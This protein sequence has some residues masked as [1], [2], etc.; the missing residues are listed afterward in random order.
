M[1][2]FVSNK[3]A[4]FT[5]ICLLFRNALFKEW[6]FSQFISSN[7][8]LYFVYISFCEET[9]NQNG[10]S[11]TEITECFAGNNLETKTAYGGIIYKKPYIFAFHQESDS[12]Q[13][14]AILVITSATRRKCY[15]QTL[16]RIGPWITLTKEMVQKILLL[17]VS[18]IA[19]LHTKF[20]E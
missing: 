11:I 15:T 3:F 8:F 4:H 20:S 13:H 17:F 1:K 6:L 5:Y 7:Y 10:R 14:N 12:F 16:P 18:A 2:K 19:N 9:S